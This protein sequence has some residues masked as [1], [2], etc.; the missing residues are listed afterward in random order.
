MAVII[1]KNTKIAVTRWMPSYILYCALLRSSGQF[2]RCAPEALSTP[3]HEQRTGSARP[4]EGS[5]PPSG[6]TLLDTPALRPTRRAVIGWAAARR[7]AGAG[8]SSQVPQPAIGSG[9]ARH[10]ND[11]GSAGAAGQHRHRGGRPAGVAPL[12]FGRERPRAA[13]PVPGRCRS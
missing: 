11:D 9:R 2:H 13:L 3:S 8:R 4:D 5:M 10:H 6:L 12:H 7:V 1:D